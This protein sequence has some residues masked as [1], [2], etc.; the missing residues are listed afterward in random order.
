MKPKSRQQRHPARYENLPCAPKGA[1]LVYTGSG[2]G[3]RGSQW[4]WERGAGD[5]VEESLGF[6]R[7]W[8]AESWARDNMIEFHPRNRSGRQPS[9]TQQEE[10]RA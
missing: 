3:G 9:G 8:H 1:T 6:E 5:D 2:S 7:R 10:Q 4:Y